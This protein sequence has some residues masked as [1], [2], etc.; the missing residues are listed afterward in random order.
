MYI[1]IVLF[2]YNL[3]L[4]SF[5]IDFQVISRSWWNLYLHDY[6]YNARQFLCTVMELQE[7]L[8]VETQMKMQFRGATA[9]LLVLWVIVVVFVVIGALIWYFRSNIY[10]QG[11]V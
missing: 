6:N 10:S 5:F 1:F 4:S 2:N 11:T 8:R 3:Q 9:A 7:N